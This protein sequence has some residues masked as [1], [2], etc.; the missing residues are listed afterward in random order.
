MAAVRACEPHQIAVHGLLVLPI[1]M[2]VLE[3]I[4]D[5]NVLIVRR[6]VVVGH[7]KLVAVRVLARDRSTAASPGSSVTSAPVWTGQNFRKEA[8][9]NFGNPHRV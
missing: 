7:A 2:V 9:Q 1:V 6:V 4:V 5:A 3:I 8:G